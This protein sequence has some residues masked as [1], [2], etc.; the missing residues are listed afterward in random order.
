MSTINQVN[1]FSVKSSPRAKVAGKAPVGRRSVS[2][3]WELFLIGVFTLAGH[4]LLLD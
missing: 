2:R 3:R 4:V 1:R